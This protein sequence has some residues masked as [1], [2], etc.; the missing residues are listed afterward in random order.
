MRK[1]YLQ[2]NFGERLSLVEA[3]VLWLNHPDGLGMTMDKSYASVLPGFFLETRS[4]EAQDPITGTLVFRQKNTYEAFIKVADWIFRAQAL[5]LIYCP[6]GTNE[7]KRDINIDHIGKSEKTLSSFLECPVIFTPLT[8][9]Y[10]QFS[11]VFTFSLENSDLFKRYPYRYEY[12]YA[13][14]FKPGSVDFTI[15]GH[16]PGSVV[17]EATGPVVTPV[18][19]LKATFDDT[20]Y[21]KVDLNSLNVDSGDKLVF[22]SRVNDPGV[23]IERGDGTV[24]DMVDSLEL[25]ADVET[26]FRVPTNTPVTAIL[27][28]DGVVPTSVLLRVMQYY[29]LR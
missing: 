14:S 22:S 21:G 7:Y 16:Y 27:E 29:R 24:E 9:W 25:Y 11:H 6:Y 26:F 1:F 18:F 12:R 15:G 28:V 2:N 19:T 20:V 3:G 23:W 13:G 4:D 8:P 10:D 17:I 5:T